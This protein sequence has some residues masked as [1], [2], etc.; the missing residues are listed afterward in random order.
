MDD[1]D[2]R[3]RMERLS[4]R[5]DGAAAPDLHAVRERHARRRSRSALVVGLGVAL[6]ATFLAA[7]VLRPSPRVPSGEPTWELPERATVWPALDTPS[8]LAWRQ[9]PERLIDRFVLLVLGWDDPGVYP[10]GAEGVYA[11]E[12]P[13]PAGARCVSGL[14]MSVVQDGSSGAWSVLA[15]VHPDL[16][17]GLPTDADPSELISGGSVSFDLTLPPSASA[18]VGLV[19]TNGCRDVSSYEVGLGSGPSGLPVPE[20][21]EDDPACSDIGAGYAFVYVTD[22]TTEPVGDPFLEAAGIEYP[23]ITA[24]PVFMTMESSGETTTATP[25]TAADVLTITCDGEGTSIDHSTV[26]AGPGGVAV[27]ISPN[28][29][30]VWLYDGRGKEVLVVD[31]GPS[32]LDLAPGTHTVGCIYEGDL[33]LGEETFE[34]ADP[35]GL[36]VDPELICPQPA[37]TDFDAGPIDLGEDPDAALLAAAE[38]ILRVDTPS[39]GSLLFGG[40][41]A[42]RDHRWVVLVTDDGKVIGRVGFTANGQDWYPDGYQTCEGSAIF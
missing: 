32:M 8:D 22:D 35:E 11:V 42:S 23:W 30:R 24:V 13:C 39:G 16:Q 19:A 36:W 27:D 40:Y 34:V 26:V 9:D 37:S 7:S 10:L 15:V 25:S 14:Q 33:V 20:P 12:P 2:L 29:E 3:E 6:I 4:R 41:P 31:D 18:H 38:A 21:I 5:V 1:L 28:N 17:V